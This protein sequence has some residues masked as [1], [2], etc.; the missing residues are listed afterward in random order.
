MK[1]VNIN[2]LIPILVRTWMRLHSNLSTNTITVDEAID[3]AAVIAK[4]I[5]KETGV[6]DKVVVVNE[7]K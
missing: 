3:I 5:A 6:S 7:D 4:S 1:P 2:P